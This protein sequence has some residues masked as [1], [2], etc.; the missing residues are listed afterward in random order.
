MFGIVSIYLKQNFFYFAL[1]S[2][3]E[4]L[5]PLFVLRHICNES[6][7]DTTPHCRLSIDLRQADDTHKRDECV[8]AFVK[9]KRERVRE[10]EKKIQWVSGI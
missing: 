1:K 6:L 10:R 4:W 5:R 3:L 9:E 8:C 7:L 2:L